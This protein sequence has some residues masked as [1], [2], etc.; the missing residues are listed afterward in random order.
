MWKSIDYQEYREIISHANVSWKHVGTGQMLWSTAGKMI[1][2]ADPQDDFFKW[3]D[4][5]TKPQTKH[6]HD[7]LSWDF[8]DWIPADM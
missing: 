2:K 3:V 5:H 1:A 4:E 7:I 8:Q 6:D